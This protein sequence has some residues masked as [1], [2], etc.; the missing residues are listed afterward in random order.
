MVAPAVVF[1]FILCLLF[2]CASPNFH[3]RFSSPFFFCL[4]SFWKFKKMTETAW[5]RAIL[6][7]NEGQALV[8]QKI[9]IAVFLSPVEIKHDGVSDYYNSVWHNAN[10]VHHDLSKTA[11]GFKLWKYSRPI[12]FEELKIIT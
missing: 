7:L 3:R 5:H 9:A 12:G 11:P 4:L 2:T 10:Y 8:T 1:P 6:D